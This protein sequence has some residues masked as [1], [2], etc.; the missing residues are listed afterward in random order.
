[1]VVTALVTKHNH[2]NRKVVNLSEQLT[3]LSQAQFHAWNKTPW[4][5]AG[6]EWKE[7]WKTVEPFLPLIIVEGVGWDGQAWTPDEDAAGISGRRYYV[8]H[9]DMAAE[10]APVPLYSAL[11]DWDRRWRYVE[12]LAA[13]ACPCC[14]QRALTCI[15]CQC[16]M[17]HCVLSCCQPTKTSSNIISLCGLIK[18]YWIQFKWKGWLWFLWNIPSDIPSENLTP[19]CWIVPHGVAT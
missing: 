16:C 14:R 15:T 3:E 12:T 9:Q 11:V 7:R 5:R 4:S 19:T 18:H 13:S 10:P 6:T 17:W 1:M 2:G 8:F